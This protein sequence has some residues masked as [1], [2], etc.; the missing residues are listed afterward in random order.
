MLRFPLII[1]L[2][3]PNAAGK[4]EVAAALL[5]L[6]FGYHSLSDVVRQE[7]RRRGLT[8]TRENLIRVGNDLRRRLGPGVLAR[9]VARHLRG[10]DIVDSIRNPSEVEV[11][12]GK[13]GFVLLG[14]DAPRR[15]RYRR[16]LRRGRPGDATSFREFVDKE[17]RENSRRGSAQQLRH[18][19]ALA[20]L[21]LIND[22]SL[23]TLENRVRRVMAALSAASGGAPAAPERVRAARRPETRRCGR[24]RRSPSLP[25]RRP[26][27]GRRTTARE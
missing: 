14:V 2:T 8:P 25:G 20:D 7:A 12:R 21:K 19:L 22:S 13:R 18:T 15:L 3:G 23:R 5:R 9:R 27:A 17:R 24:T 6:G 26:R 16:S 11:L 4:G 1:G 10:R